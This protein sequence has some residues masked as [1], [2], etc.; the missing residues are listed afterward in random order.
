MW[1]WR[2]SSSAAAARASTSRRSR[3][4]TR[5]CAP[6]T[7]HPCARQRGAVR[8][9]SDALSA[10]GRCGEKIDVTDPH[11]RAAG[12][13]CVPA[14]AEPVV[15]DG[16]GRRRRSRA[17][18]PAQPASIS[19]LDGAVRRP[20]AASRSGPDRP[21][22]PA[23][24]NRSGA[25]ARGVGSERRAEPLVGALVAVDRA[26]SPRRRDGS[27]GDQADAR[28]HSSA[29]HRA[30]RG[31]RAAI[32]TR[33]SSQSAETRSSS[34][35][36]VT[37]SQ[38]RRAPR[39]RSSREIDRNRRDVSPGGAW[40][41]PAARASRLRSLSTSRQL[42]GAGSTRRDRPQRRAGAAAEIRSPRP[43][44]RPRTR[45]RPHRAPRRCA[46]RRS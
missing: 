20:E 24:R 31:A 21:R 16:H 30:A 40:L 39:S 4:A 9:R 33:R 43:P 37:R 3:D 42:C 2:R 23:A 13:R 17:A 44:A 26:R 7:A 1:W 38:V 41:V 5:R 34:A 35:E 29:P 28:R 18:A 27:A 10:A 32:A 19:S 14:L 11:V 12:R 25:V 22:S 45:P 8:L 6:P 36:V 46:P 15:D